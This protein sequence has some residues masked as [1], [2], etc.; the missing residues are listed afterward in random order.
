MLTLAAAFVGCTKDEWPDQ[1]DWSRIPDPSI[2]VDD[3][4]MKPAA[5]SN[6]VVAHR[7][8]A[9][10]CG[11]PD[12]SMAALEYAMSLGCY[13]MECDIYWTKDNDIIVA[14][15][16]GDCKV[17]NLQ[18]W[19]ATVAELRAAGRLSNGEELPTLEEFI[20][21]VMVEGN[22]TRLVLDVKRVDKPYAQPEYV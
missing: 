15:A 3:G 8:G 2:P 19:T 4:F 22:C 1:P 21:R 10:E 5:C 11:A 6:T 16:N 17:N 20:R 13:G 9:A 14:H 12:N 18:P 7:G